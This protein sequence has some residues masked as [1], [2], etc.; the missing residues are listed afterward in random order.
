MKRGVSHRDQ[1]AAYSTKDGS[2]I[3][4]LIHPDSHP[5]RN[6]SLAEASLQPGQRT[7][8][9]RHR[10]SEEIYY[11]LAGSGRM[12]LDSDE[13]SVSAGDSIL[14]PPGSA[15]CIANTGIEALR[16]LCCCAP[17]YA[18]ADTDLIEVE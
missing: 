18:H 2:E 4:E 16:L 6:Q 10:Q 13:F 11:V 1:V 17:A 15:H 5:A 9:H 7:A 14:I 3:R 12:I 8:L